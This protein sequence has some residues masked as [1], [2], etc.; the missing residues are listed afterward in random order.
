MS[1]LPKKI[2]PC[3]IVEAVIQ[4]R[5]SSILPS[6]A[7][8]GV[9]YTKVGP[10]FGKVNKLPILQIPEAVRSKDPNLTYQ[11]HYSLVKK[12]LPLQLNI[13]PRTITFSNVDNYIGWDKFFEFVNEVLEKIKDTD[14]IHLPERIGIRYIN[15]F[16]VQ[17]LDK[18]NLEINL[19]NSKINTESTHFRTEIKDDNFITVVQLNNNVPLNIKGIEKKGSLIDIDCIYNFDKP[20]PSLYTEFN[21]IIKSGHEKEK[22]TFFKLLKDDF[23]NEFDLEY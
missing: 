16:D 9:I 21:S 17:I 5:F 6:E 1:E 18:V 19:N 15:F 8:F 7:I 2:S 20:D 22:H 3:P 14:V 10:D 12:D 11:A 23:L 4:I 13:G